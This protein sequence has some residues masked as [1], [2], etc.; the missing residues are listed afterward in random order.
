MEEIN[1]AFNAIA[2]QHTVLCYELGR[3]RRTRA[4]RPVSTISD[5]EERLE[6]KIEALDTALR[7][8]AKIIEND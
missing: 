3:L 7:S 4:Q 5:Y 6:L 2:R 1:N 8:L